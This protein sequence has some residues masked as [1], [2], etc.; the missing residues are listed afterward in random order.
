MDELS[1]SIKGLEPDL[2]ELRHR[3]H[4]DPEL[5]DQEERTSTVVADRLLALGLKV[6]AGVGGHGVI[7]RLQGD[8]PGRTIALRADMDALPIQ[9][10]NDVPY[11]SRNPGVMHA[12]GHDGHT[13]ILLGAA[14][15]LASRRD[16]IAG[17]V[18]FLF[19]HA[20]ET[21]DGARR[22]V[23]GGAM[24][25]V[26]AVLGLHGW[27]YVGLGQIGIRS[28]PMMASADTFDITIHGVGAHAAYP[29]LA[30][31]P[32]LIGGQIVTTLQSLSSREV[33]PNQP[34]VVT[35]AQFH[36]GTAYNIIPGTARIAGTVRTLN[37]ELRASMPDRIRRIAE[38]ICAA[39]RATCEMQYIEGTP[40]VVNDSSMTDLVRETASEVL[41]PENVI[42]VPHPSMG[43]E[44]FAVYLERAPGTMFRLGLGPVSN[45]H[46]PT[47]NFDDRAVPVGIELFV[48]TAERFLERS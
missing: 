8:Q 25:G 41:G 36:A 30:V 20:E 45:L 5:S 22:M 33:D 47:F 9:E 32:I 27:P 29:H 26:D 18:R 42:D 15:L 28:G 48:R 7:A 23:Q 21:V 40:P 12:C 14:Q 10:E 17:E 3:L 13:T 35:V 11:R 38:G 2:I 19:Q 31:D 37:T 34:V 6:R 16:R 44:D 1:A 46:T 39:S 43:A 24:D 4:Q